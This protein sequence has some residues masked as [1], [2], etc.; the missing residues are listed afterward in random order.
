LKRLITANEKHIN[1]AIMCS[2]ANPK[3]CHRTKLI[4]Q[5]LLK[6]HISLKHIVGPDKSKPQE[7]VMNELNKGLPVVD[8]FGNEINFT[9]RKSY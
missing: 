6:S 1:L 8:L 4:G 2:E 3:E 7:L 9:S 5:E